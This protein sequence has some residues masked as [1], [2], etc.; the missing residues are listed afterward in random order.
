MSNYYEDQGIN[1]YK[2]ALDLAEREYNANRLENLKKVRFIQE[3]IQNYHPKID[4]LTLICLVNV[5]YKY[6]QSKSTSRRG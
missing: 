2:K 1:S 5:V 3:E 6:D 4:W